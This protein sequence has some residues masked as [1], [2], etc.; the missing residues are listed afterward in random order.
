MTSNKNFTQI[1]PSCSLDQPQFLLQ[2]EVLKAHRTEQSRIF[3][4]LVIYVKAFATF[5]PQKQTTLY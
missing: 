1:C 2:G 4:E 5:F 3:K